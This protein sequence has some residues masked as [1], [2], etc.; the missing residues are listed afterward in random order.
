[1]LTVEELGI[2]AVKVM[3]D[4]PEDDPDVR[5]ASMQL[6]VAAQKMYNLLLPKLRLRQQM[7]ETLIK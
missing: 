4:L 5:L 3:G 6:C 7:Y 1:M 2:I